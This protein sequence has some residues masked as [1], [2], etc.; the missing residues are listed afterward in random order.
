MPPRDLDPF[1]KI[2]RPGDDIACSER[3]AEL[4]ANSELRKSRLDLAAQNEQ[5]WVNRIVGPNKQLKE[6][7]IQKQRFDRWLEIARFLA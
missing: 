6:A 7:L 1:L 4:D 3:G 5:A 2:A